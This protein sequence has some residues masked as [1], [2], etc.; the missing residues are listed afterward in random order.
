[1]HGKAYMDESANTL[2]GSTQRTC[3]KFFVLSTAATLCL[4]SRCVGILW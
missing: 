3:V 2:A 1:M 4:A